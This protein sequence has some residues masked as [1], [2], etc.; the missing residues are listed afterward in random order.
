MTIDF[1]TPVTPQVHALSMRLCDL[2]DDL[3]EFAYQSTELA[4]HPETSTNLRAKLAS[5]TDRLIESAHRINERRDWAS[6]AATGNTHHTK[7]HAA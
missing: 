2:I 7:D 1:N 5:L 3:H 4:K 6:N